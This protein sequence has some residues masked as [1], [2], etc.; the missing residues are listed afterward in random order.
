MW[1]MKIL[2]ESLKFL[3]VHEQRQALVST[4][5][6]YSTKK[7]G[8]ENGGC[9]LWI[10]EHKYYIHTNIPKMLKTT[11][12][13]QCNHDSS[14]DYENILPPEENMC[15]VIL[16]SGYIHIKFV[17]RWRFI[18]HDSEPSKTDLELKRK[19]FYVLFFSC[20]S[21]LAYNYRNMI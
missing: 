17:V 21:S 1:L 8:D 13:L 7:E 20:K 9:F 11:L 12:V 18:Y 3:T 14:Y 4:T 2:E 6:A 10:W 15:L 5:V 19:L 16:S